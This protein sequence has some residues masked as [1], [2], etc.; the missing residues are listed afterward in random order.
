[1][2]RLWIFDCVYPYYHHLGTRIIHFLLLS[3][4]GEPITEGS[5]ERWE[6]HKDQVAR[7]NEQ[8]LS[9]GVLYNDVQYTNV[10]CNERIQ[11]LMFIDLER[12][13]R[14]PPLKPKLLQFTPPPASSIV[15]TR[16]E[17]GDHA[18]AITKVNLKAEEV[19]VRARYE[20]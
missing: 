3:W 15:S 13:I 11:Q 18:Q 5:Q 6:T 14:I 17:Q 9:L 1:M 12:S 4:A 20:G 8:L 2:I 16:S 7:I 19:I 10:L